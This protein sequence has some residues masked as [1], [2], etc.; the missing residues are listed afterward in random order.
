MEVKVL[1]DKFSL[2]LESP[3]I[4]DFLQL[5]KTVGWG[6]LDANLAEKSLNNS[7]FHVVIYHD[8]QLIGMGRV[9]GDGAMYFYIQDIIVDPSYQGQGIGTVLMD[10]VEG[11]LRYTV[12]KGSTIGLLAA[13]GK[14]GFYARYGY[15]Q[16]PNNTLGNGMCKFI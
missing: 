3:I 12:T 2:K 9:I 13:K 6:D 1:P 14:E 16:R 11:Y 4:E 7:L 5:R 10:T 15:I 8:E